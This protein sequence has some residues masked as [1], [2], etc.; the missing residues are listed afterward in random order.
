MGLRGLASQ[1]PAASH[2]VLHP[3]SGSG[4]GRAQDESLSGTGPENAPGAKY[5]GALYLVSVERT[6]L[7][8]GL[9]VKYS[10]IKHNHQ[11]NAFQPVEGGFVLHVRSFSFDLSSQAEH[12][13][14]LRQIIGAVR[15][16]RWYAVGTACLSGNMWKEPTCSA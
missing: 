6:C 11:A 10:D 16:R 7:L 13:R 9:Q 2:G 12:C 3:R 4:P 14:A 1:H 5:L 8:L 15:F